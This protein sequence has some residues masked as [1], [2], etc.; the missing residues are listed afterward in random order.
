MALAVV[1]LM[2]GIVA[3]AASPAPGAD[4]A[5]TQQLTCSWTNLGN[6][7]R[8]LHFVAS[9]IDTDQNKLYVYGGVNASY[10]AQSQVEVADF[11]GAT[12]GV[13]H[14]TV[15]ASGSRALVGA[16]GAYRAKGD[17][18]ESAVYFFGGASDPSVGQGGN[19]VQRYLTKAG[20]W[21]VVS[22]ANAT[23]FTNRLG[24]AAEYDPE[25]DVIWVVG[26]V[27]Q[28]KL[29]DVIGGGQCNARSLTTVYLSFDPTTGQPT[30]NTL[31]GGAQSVYAHS[32]V[33][34][35]A[36]KRML[37]FGGTNTI[38]SGQSTLLALDLSDPDPD[39]ASFSTLATTG[40]APSVLF[41]GAAYDP[42]QNW[43]IVAG[44][45]TNNFLTNRE[46]TENNTHALDLGQTPPAWVSLTSYRDRVAGA[47]AYVPNHGV[48]VFT[49][50][51][52]KVT[53][54][55]SPRI[56]RRTDAL[57]C[58]AAPPPTTP[59]PV[60]PTT[61][62]P[63]QPGP[64]PTAPPQPTPVPAPEECA[65]VANKVPGQARADALANPASV[66]GYQMLCNPNLPPSPFNTMRNRLSMQNAAKPYHPMYNGLVWSCGCP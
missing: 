20:R 11:S 58:G 5:P 51:R 42:V 27:T 34:D 14:R 50:G 49:L 37:I 3:V 66:Y 61:P 45:A 54:P 21:E 53:N 41:H 36:G 22:P 62:A 56:D 12:L 2:L 16:A 57:V 39:K 9:A 13:S 40:R 63:T 55:E 10:A 65:F 25:H 29:S 7:T 4:A 6:S 46:A 17:S 47:M 60:E 26:G 1:A 18:D 52:N 19:V 28:C 31:A 8:E 30:W 43:M 33:Y 32:M 35:S 24:A 38:Q 44:G 15:T 48:A 64:G 59:P 23:A